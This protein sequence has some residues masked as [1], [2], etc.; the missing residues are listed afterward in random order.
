MAD[1]SAMLFTAYIAGV[2]ALTVPPLWVALLLV[3]EGRPAD[4]L[5]RWSLRLVVRV[6]GCR[7][8]V[9][10]ADRL[11]RCGPAMLV[12][13]HASYLDSVILMAALSAEFR[14]VAN[15]GLLAWPLIGMIVRKARHLT[16]NR[17]VRAQRLACTRAMA[18]VLR[19]GGSLLVYPEGTT[20][21]QPG[22]LPFRLGAF[23]AAVLAGRPIVPITVV[24]TGRVWRRD[25]WLLRRAPVGVTIHEPIEPE[26]GDRPEMVRIRL[27]A[28]SQIAAGLSAA[29]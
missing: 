2:V 9:S 3:P 21:R 16:V 8:R 12:A 23:R 17:G 4:R 11:L 27:R 28:R 10:G 26:A 14:F 13:N 6:S 1:L 19:Q 25:G 24:G 29:C 22:L 5:V 18:D 20:S 15:H 7:L